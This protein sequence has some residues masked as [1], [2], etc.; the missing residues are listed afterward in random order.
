M[1]TYNIYLLF[2][3]VLVVTGCKVSKDVETPQTELPQAYR[4]A[5]VSTDTTSVATIEWK[6][7]FPD[8]N[9]QELI[10]KAVANNYDLQIA[11]KNIESA[12]LQLTQSKWNNVPQ[13]NLGVTANTSIP[14]Q[15]SLNGISLNN[16]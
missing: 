8:T 16:F 9:L 11:L 7:F 1:K 13:L 10:G 15:N 5:P 6:Q 4:N 2:A 3:L 14:S 12:Q